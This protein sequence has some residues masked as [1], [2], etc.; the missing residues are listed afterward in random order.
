MRLRSLRLRAFG[1]FAAEQVIDFERLASSGLFLLEG[2]TG[3]GKSTILDA[4]TFALYGG[5]AGESS[6]DDRLRSHFAD[7]SVEPAVQCEFSL[8]GLT[9][10]VERI[11]EHTRPKKRGDGFTTEAARVHLERLEGG[12]WV[13]ISANKAE[14]GAAITEAVGLNRDQFT[15]VMLLPQG[16]FARFLRAGDDERRVVLTKLFGTGLY[17][18][19]TSEL[20]RRRAEALKTRDEARQEITA[21]VSAAAGAAGLDEGERAELI[22]L[23]G[24][25][26]GVRFK[27]TADDLAGAVATAADA[28]TSAQDRL[29]RAVAA[30]EQ[31]K[32]EADLMSRLTRALA[33]LAG[34]EATRAAYERDRSTLSAARRADPIAPFIASLA[35]AEATEQAAL[36]AVSEAVPGAA[37]G[38]ATPARLA[39]LAAAAAD[40]AMRAERDAERLSHPAEAE[41]ALAA[42][43]AALADLEQS[44]QEALGKVAD[45]ARL[46]EGLPARIA[47]LAGRCEQA[48][49]AAAGLEA[50]R[51]RLDAAQRQ[52]TGAV[53]AAELHAEAETA[54]SA[55]L[56][57]VEAHLAAFERHN[58][59]TEARLA[60]IAAELAGTLVDGAP[61]PVCGSGEHPAP[62]AARED[63]VSPA[64]VAR[65]AQ[66]RDRAE[67]ARRAAEAQYERLAREEAAAIAV[68]GGVAAADLLAQVQALTLEITVAEQ[69]HAEAVSCEA[70]LAA[71]RELLESSADALRRAERVAAA[72]G[73]RVAAAR[74][75]LE[76][77]RVE[78][79]EAAQ[80]YPSVAARQ[81]ALREAATRHRATAESLARLGQARAAA[82]KARDQAELQAH[83]RGFADVAQAAA[84]V[85]DAVGQETLSKRVDTWSATMAGLTAAATADDLSGLDPAHA[86]AVRQAA[87]EAE[88]ER[89]AAAEADRSARSAYDKAVD[90]KARFETCLAE[91]QRAEAGYDELAEATDEVIRLASLAKGVEG[92][93]R[94]ALT[95]Y[96]LRHWFAQVVAAANVRL[97]AMSSGRYELRRTDVGESRRERSGLTLAV[98]DRYTGE[99]RSPASLSG[100]ETFYTSLALALGLADV[101][102][103]ES[104]GVDLDTLFIDEGFGSL[105]SQTL[106]QV[107]AAID[108]LRERGRVVGIVSHIADLKDRVPERLEVRRLPDGSSAVRIVA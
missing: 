35:E 70:E 61:C 108:E 62:A 12:R 18:R 28:M 6:S 14:V 98:V 84:A 4:V 49:Q 73:E 47:D 1:P 22:A 29:T 13:S 66:Q 46:R 33:R 79:A 30:S 64:D 85:L 86:D 101:V 3:A 80:G 72:S 51:V 103:A 75:A 15:Q 11:P 96:V 38:Q 10:R 53:R 68:S 45:L 40:A 58:A 83:A 7:S 99:E 25:E 34:H 42:Q 105:D 44:E 36:V 56:A 24:P 100:G 77:A 102:K 50:A 95:T 106:D 91:V 93:R 59:L 9:Y 31:A 39:E 69:A 78:I 67:S 16:E 19:V 32:R 60:G 17:D 27:Q 41:E 65:A 37:Q 87:A 81:H 82:A 107:M 90:R 54:R 26:R 52:R 97:S 21:A 92:Q 2:P 94:V 23:T 5:L 8:R 20:D 104:G 76:G 71:A 55:M 48:R 43:Q 89:L 57:A 63:S 74:T 88:R